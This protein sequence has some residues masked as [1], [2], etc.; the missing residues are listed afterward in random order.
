MHIQINSRFW[1]LLLPMLR[2]RMRRLLLL[3]LL[4]LLLRLRCLAS[5]GGRQQ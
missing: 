5:F 1:C 2:R 3:L 4:L